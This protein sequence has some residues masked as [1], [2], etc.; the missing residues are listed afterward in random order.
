MVDEKFVAYIDILGFK[1]M[2]SKRNAGSKIERFYQSI[3]DLWK[4]EYDPLAG[5]L[6]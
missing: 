5:A 6:N 1:D 4:K 3:Y 2:V